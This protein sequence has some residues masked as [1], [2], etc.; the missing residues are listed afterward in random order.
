MYYTEKL[1][2]QVV[3]L[4]LQESL[5]LEKLRRVGR[6]LSDTTEGLSKTL[7]SKTL[8]EIENET[9]VG[10]GTT[11]PVSRKTE[12]WT[13]LFGP[14]QRRVVIPTPVHVYVSTQNSLFTW[15]NFLLS[16]SPLIRRK[17]GKGVG[18]REETQREKVGE[19][20]T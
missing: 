7:S 12:G 19:T 16:P 5:E 17:I 3:S 11:S 2:S 15:Y 20:Q 18:R 14:F 10:V 8:G 6:Q 9:P 1:F 13:S 4:Y